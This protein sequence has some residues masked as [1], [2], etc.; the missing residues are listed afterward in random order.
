MTVEIP[1]IQKTQRPERIDIGDGL[2]MHWST[3][4]DVENI[5][6]CMAVAFKVPFT[7]FSYALH[8]LM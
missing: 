7:F 3:I 1:I 4:K 5:A 6:D 2:V 8:L